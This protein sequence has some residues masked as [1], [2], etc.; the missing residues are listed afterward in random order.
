MNKYLKIGFV[1]AFILALIF[2]PTYCGLNQ[3]RSIK[4]PINNNNQYIS[5]A[6][7]DSILNEMA[8]DKHILQ[9]KYDSLQL[10]KQKVIK[11]RERVRDSL[12][13]ISDST[14][15]KTINVLYY[16]CQKTD[17]VN[18][19]IILNLQEQNKKDSSSISALKHKINTKQERITIDSTRIVALIDTIPRV[20][21]K[22]FFKGFAIGFGIGAAAKQGVDILTKIKPLEINS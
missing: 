2:I 1:A 7:D 19:N 14:C 3:F 10:V 12:I 18:N 4:T 22:G 13:Y 11:G 8:R 20:K 15:I 6:K 5:E 17:S 9:N 16:E 21:R